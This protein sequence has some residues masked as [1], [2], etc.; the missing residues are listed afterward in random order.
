MM[1]NLLAGMV[2]LPIPP[3]KQEIIGSRSWVSSFETLGIH[4][5]FQTLL[6]I[7]KANPF[8]LNLNLLLLRINTHKVKK[9]KIQT[10]T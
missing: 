10:L 6:L 5:L 1:T 9:S 4:T 3:S 7:P 8:L 2:F